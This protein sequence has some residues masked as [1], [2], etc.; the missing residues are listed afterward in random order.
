MVTQGAVTVPAPQPDADTNDIVI[1]KPDI[2]GTKQETSA[3]TSGGSMMG[4]PTSA[5]QNAKTA[6]AAVPT[7]KQVATENKVYNQVDETRAPLYKAPVNTNEIFAKKPYVKVDESQQ[8]Q[9][10]DKPDLGEFTE[11]GNQLSEEDAGDFAGAQATIKSVIED[12]SEEDKKEVTDNYFNRADEEL[13]KKANSKWPLWATIASVALFA[14][15]GGSI[16]PVNFIALSGQKDAREKWNTLLQEKSEWESKAPSEMRGEVTAGEVATESPEQIKAATEAQTEIA[17]AQQG[18][19]SE[20]GQ[21]EMENAYNI[22]EKQLKLSHQ[23]AVDFMKAQ[24][25]ENTKSQIDILE[26][27]RTNTIS[28][29]DAATKNQAGLLADTAKQWGIPLTKDGLIQL[30]RAM[31]GESTFSKYSGQLVQIAEEAIKLAK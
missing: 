3:Q 5:I 16:P 20:L 23:Q 4:M 21:K 30:Q 2:M 15:S 9:K 6:G 12:G 19:G 25:E 22:L 8:P 14:I 26:K 10:S 24:T 28:I 7:A 29:N 31:L 11:I 13:K 17:A 27:M 18:K 1:K